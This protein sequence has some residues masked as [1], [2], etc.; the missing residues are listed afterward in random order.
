MTTSLQPGQRNAAHGLAHNR[1]AKGI[2]SGLPQR[3]ASSIGK[4]LAGCG[5]P[6]RCG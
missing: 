6:G 5:G 3:R 1:A 4:T 2:E